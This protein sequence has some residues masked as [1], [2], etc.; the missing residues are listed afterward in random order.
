[1]PTHP[2]PVPQEW[3]ETGDW[4]HSPKNLNRINGCNELNRITIIRHRSQNLNIINH[5][6]DPIRLWMA[7]GRHG[8]GLVHTAITSA[9]TRVIMCTLC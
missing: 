1:M 5:I 6:H 2:P 3:L 9:I 7:S 4:R 8:L